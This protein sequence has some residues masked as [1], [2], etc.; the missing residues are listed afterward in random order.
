MLRCAQWESDFTAVQL[1]QAV[2]KPKRLDDG[3]DEAEEIMKF[4]MEQWLKVKLKSVEVDD[5]AQVCAQ[6]S[7]LCCGDFHFHTLARASGLALSGHGS[8][9]PGVHLGAGCEDWTLWK[10][11]PHAHAAHLPR[12]VAWSCIARGCLT[13]IAGCRS[14]RN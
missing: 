14:L 8:T 5:F 10:A 9:Q 2:V 7:S 3:N 11:V 4:T 1:S 13:K 6:R 12:C